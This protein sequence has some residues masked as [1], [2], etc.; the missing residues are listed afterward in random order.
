MSIARRLSP[1]LAVTVVFAALLVPTAAQADDAAFADAFATGAK[2]LAAKE[3]TAQ[4]ALSRVKGADDAPKAQKAVRAAQRGARSLA[5]KL[6]AED[7]SSA[8]GSMAQ[9]LVV[10]ALKG[11][12]RAY[13]QIDDALA[14][15]AK[16]DTAKGDRL[17]AR[18]KKGLARAANQA[19]AA[20]RLIAAALGGGGAT[21]QPR[22]P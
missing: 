12:D 4:T 3:R 10:T 14:A 21:G 16:G 1:L 5:R 19:K 18:A 17:V 20:A 7:P 2:A 6:A 22:R 11:E 13:G 9:K 8:D 15:A